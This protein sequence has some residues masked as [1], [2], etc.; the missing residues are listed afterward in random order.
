MPK[1]HYS[2]GKTLKIDGKVISE[3]IFLDREKGH[4]ETHAECSVVG[5]GWH[6]KSKFNKG[7]KRSY[8]RFEGD[9]GC[10][11]QCRKH[12]KRRKKELLK[13][14]PW[15][16]K[17]WSQYQRDKAI[18]TPLEKKVYK[19]YAGKRTAQGDEVDITYEEWLK[20][21]WVDTCPY[22]HLKF[23]N[24]AGK[25]GRRSDSPSIDRIDSSKPY[26]KYNI[27]VVSWRYNHC[28]TDST[29]EERFAMGGE[30]AK[31]LGYRW[32]P[33]PA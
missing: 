7:S 22:F 33:E 16:V 9:R 24:H 6:I 28:K 1:G 17:K 30:A 31:K 10:K 2:R 8:H 25:N 21:Y 23:V 20:D 5:C 11:L 4:T 27:E 15:Q 32:P 3:M 12:E 14:S 29:T 19:I 18:N 13:A 26:S